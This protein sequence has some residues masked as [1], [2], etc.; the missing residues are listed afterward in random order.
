MS[1]STPPQS[2]QPTSPAYQPPEAG[3]VTPPPAPPKKRRPW[4]QWALI[5]V[6]VVLVIAVA[7]SMA[8]GGG[9]GTTKTQSGQ[10]PA[11][12]QVP[13]QAPIQAPTQVPTQAPTQ[14]PKQM[15]VIQ[16]FEGNQN[17]KTPT[18]HVPDSATL[19]WSAKPT[20]EYG[21]YFS[22]ITYSSDGQYGDLIANTGLSSTQSGKYTFHG[23]AD[24]YLDVS[25]VNASYTI[26]ISALQ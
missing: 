9:K 7:S 5:V 3:P 8:N 17:T 21:G 16:K 15:V 4:W 23:D 13:T 12:T 26:T 14:A 18:F 11:V 10:P 20:S 1:I 19:E 6:G 22:I 2:G 25:A 24:I